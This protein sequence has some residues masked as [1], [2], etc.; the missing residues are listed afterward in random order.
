MSLINGVL[1]LDPYQSGQRMKKQAKK[2]SFDLAGVLRVCRSFQPLRFIVTAV[3]LLL[4]CTVFSLS[5]SVTP[6]FS[7]EY[8]A[9]S[10]E[11]TTGVETLACSQCH[12][13][14]GSQGGQTLLYEGSTLTPKLLRASSVTNLCLYCH[15]ST[16]PGSVGWDARTPPQVENNQQ[17]YT[18]SAGDFKHNNFTNEGNR[19]SIGSDVSS[20]PPPGYSGTWSD[21]TAR[22]GTEFN[23]EFC[24]DQHGNTNYRNLRFNPGVPGDDNA[25]SPNRVMVTYAYGAVSDPDDNTKDVN[26]WGAGADTSSANKFT[27]SRVRFRR[28]PLDSDSPARGIAAWCGKCHVDFYGPSG[29]SNMGGVASGGVVGAGDNN[30]ST[31]SPWVRHPVADINMG[32]ASTNKHV[33]ATNWTSVSSKARHINP[34]GI[35]G[36]SDDEPFCFTCHYAHGGGNPNSGGTP[37]LDH[38]NL[39]FVDG[40]GKVNIEAGYNSATGM[41]RNLCQQ[42]HNQ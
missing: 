22:Y 16:S 36:N 21:V 15:G 8:H 4:F 32:I 9:S 12:T 7:G 39:A 3:F 28:A 27:R 40:T 33:D 38:T 6:A 14:H 2:K 42:C 29:A 30:S 31:N 19:H 13:M 26:Y 11:T 17:N 41:I 1:C 35:S 37:E 18:P 5:F 25:S 23:C 24:H 10:E 34:D 20:L